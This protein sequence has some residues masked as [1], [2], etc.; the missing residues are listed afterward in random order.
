MFFPTFS[1]YYKSFDCSF[2]FFYRLQS[3]GNFVETTSTNS[4]KIA[5]E[6]I[7]TDNNKASNP[8]TP[9][10]FCFVHHLAPGDAWHTQSED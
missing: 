5:K 6:V 4:V 10:K 7:I 9:C 8:P 2:S 3:Q 1:N